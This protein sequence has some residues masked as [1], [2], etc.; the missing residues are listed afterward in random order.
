MLVVN[1]WTLL[2]IG[3]V[4]H[5]FFINFNDQISNRLL[6]NKRDNCREILKN[7]GSQTEAD[8]ELLKM[9]YSFHDEKNRKIHSN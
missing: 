4:G 3:L 8:I 1:I 7:Q 6:L 5:S 2:Y 9:R